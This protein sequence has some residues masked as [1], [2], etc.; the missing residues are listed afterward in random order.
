[1]KLRGPTL[2]RRFIKDR[3]GATAALVALAIIPILGLAGFAIDIGHALQV[4]SAL[5][6]STDAAALAAAYDIRAIGNGG[7]GDPA[8]KARLYSSASGG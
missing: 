8:A 4:K 5:Q 6:A 3:S 2:L 1:M 7:S